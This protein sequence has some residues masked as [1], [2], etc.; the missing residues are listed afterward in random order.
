MTEPQSNNA[1]FTRRSFLVGGVGVAGAIAGGG[2]LLGDAGSAAAQILG[3]PALAGSPRRGG[4]VKV[5]TIAPVSAVDPV[6]MYDAGSIAIAQQSAEYLVYV[7]ANGS[8][9]PVLATSW[10]SDKTARSWTFKLRPNVKFHDGTT[11]SSADV[12]ATFDRLVDPKSQSSALTDFQGILA[13]GGIHAVDA[14]TV[15]FDLESPFADFPYLV[16]STNYNT[17]V[18]PK[19]YKGNFQAQPVG[20]GPFIQQ[21]FTHN[22]GATFRRNPNYWDS[23]KPY[24]DEVNFTFYQ[25][26]QAQL[27]GLQGGSVDTVVTI[28]SSEIPTL[29]G[30]SGLRVRNVNGSA[31][32]TLWMRVDRKPFTDRRARQAVAWAIDRQGLIAT[33]LNGK[34]VPG[35]DHFFGPTMPFRPNNLP[36]R[37]QNLSRAKALLQAAGVHGETV[38]L[39]TENTPPAP[40]YATLVKNDLAKIGLNVKLNIMSQSAFYGSGKNQPWLEVPFGI[41]DWAARA[42]PAQYLNPVLESNGV[43]NSPHYKNPELD[44]LIRRYNATLGHAQRQSLTNQIAHITFNDVPVIVAYWDGGQR[45]MSTKLQGLQASASSFMDLSSAWLT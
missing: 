40:D 43:W 44:T 26:Q 9:R 30:T 42:I 33:A 34:A 19:A 36:Q 27:L 25:D 39:T 22:Q 3:S 4:T 20:T 37:V 15:R 14:S 32:Y 29:E 13:P 21:S 31:T 11:L 28:S 16:S 35:N 8:L 10:S 41:V 17:L 7:N 2:L 1:G 24:L 5:G 18:L 23:G 38:T 45:P 6:T 12:V